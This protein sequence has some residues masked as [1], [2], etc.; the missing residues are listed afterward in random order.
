MKEKRK[1]KMALCGVNCENYKQ[2]VINELSL[3]YEWLIVS[4]SIWQKEHK[5]VFEKPKVYSFLFKQDMLFSIL[6]WNDQK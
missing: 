4:T 2:S 6:Y 3:V 5:Y 1:K